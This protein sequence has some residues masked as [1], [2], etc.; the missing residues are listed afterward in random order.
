MQ[1]KKQMIELYDRSNEYNVEQRTLEQLQNACSNISCEE[2]RGANSKEECLQA[3]WNSLREIQILRE[4]LEGLEKEVDEIEK[5]NLYHPTA[6]PIYSEEKLAKLHQTLNFLTKENQS[7][8]ELIGAKDDKKR[9]T[10][11]ANER[12]KIAQAQLLEAREKCILVEEGLVKY[13]QKVSSL[14]RL[15]E[16]SN[17]F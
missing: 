3:Y 4:E 16:V 11:K 6:S 10:E 8:V 5:K 1:L 12:V 13:Y 14:Q 7:Y 9:E 17:P 2:G 15:L